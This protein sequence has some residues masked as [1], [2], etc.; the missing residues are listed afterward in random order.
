MFYVFTMGGQ[1]GGSCSLK[2]WKLDHWHPDMLVWTMVFTSE[3]AGVRWG[4]T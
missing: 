4:L 2:D 1:I 3:E